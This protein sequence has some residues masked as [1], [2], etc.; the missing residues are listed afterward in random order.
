MYPVRLIG[1]RTVLR[2]FRS[3]DVAAAFGVVG[4]D[5]VTVSLSF[6][7][8]S[9]DDTARMVAEI[10][11]RAARSPRT[12]Y[13]LAIV[14]PAASRLVGFVRLGLTGVRA[15]RLGY[16]IRPDSWRLGYALDAAETMLRFGFAE[17]DLHRVSAAIGPENVASIA[18]VGKLRFV[19]GG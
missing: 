9:R 7:S 18:M 12:E 11:E 15:G 8:R 4:D 6:D 19:H 3:N 17:L 13:Y 2:E 5:R 1:S 16:A 14:E 10:V